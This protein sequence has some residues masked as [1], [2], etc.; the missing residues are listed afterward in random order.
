MERKPLK[1][2]ISQK[3]SLGIMD[4]FNFGLGFTIAV[5]IVN[6]VVVPVLACIFGLLVAMGILSM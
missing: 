3:T 1:R 5:I 4:G 2:L 6:L